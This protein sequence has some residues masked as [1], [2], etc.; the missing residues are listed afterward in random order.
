MTVVIYLYIS[1][2]ILKK[3]YMKL[4][5]EIAVKSV[6]PAI[7]A[8]LAKELIENH[9]MRQANAASLLGITQTAVS[10]YSHNVRGNM[11]SIDKDSEIRIQVKKTAVLL[12][13]GKLNRTK[14]AVK[15]CII[16][17]S[18]RKKGLMCRLCRR[19]S[20]FKRQECSICQEPIC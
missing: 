16:C 18:V 20:S 15:I 8:M 1:L 4:P 5:C 3:D 14:L 12:S 9:R 13:K 2:F 11:L 6:V 17:R 7:R 10:K 19:D